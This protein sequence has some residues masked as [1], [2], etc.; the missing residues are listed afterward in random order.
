MWC[1]F[2]AVDYWSYIQVYS[3]EVPDLI[4][5]VAKNEDSIYHYID[6]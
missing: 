5:T 4:S 6:H 2:A 3:S 1:V